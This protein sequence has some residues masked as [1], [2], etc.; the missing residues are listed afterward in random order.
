M[1]LP[2][3]CTISLAGTIVAVTISSAVPPL[4]ETHVFDQQGLELQL[5]SA[6][7][8]IRVW[9]CLLLKYV[10]RNGTSVDVVPDYL[11]EYRYG[12]V[13][14]ELQREPETAWHP[15]KSFLAR[16]FQEGPSLGP[17]LAVA[18]GSG[19]VDVADLFYVGKGQ[20]VFATPGVYRLRV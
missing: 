10:I 5:R 13:T 2:H 12:Y 1:P 8:R 6:S 19:R 20:P 7:P 15:H 4:I 17:G 18:R 11:T 3:S 16:L 9:D 14:I